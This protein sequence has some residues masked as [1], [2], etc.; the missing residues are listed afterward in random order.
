MSFRFPLLGFGL[1]LGLGL[2]LE[3]G[4]EPR[5][6]DPSPR[7]IHSSFSSKLLPIPEELGAGLES[8]GFAFFVR[9]PVLLGTS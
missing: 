3:L 2:E 4:L 9:G 1:G 6:T 5:G 7:G 8:E